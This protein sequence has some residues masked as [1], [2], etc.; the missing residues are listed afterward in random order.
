MY[1]INLLVGIINNELK[2]DFY[3]QKQSEFLVINFDGYVDRSKL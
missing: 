3:G 2:N 1:D